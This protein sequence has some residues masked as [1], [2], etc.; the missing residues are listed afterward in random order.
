MF[1][2]KGI[3][4]PL[5]VKTDSALAVH[6]LKDDVI[7]S[8]SSFNMLNNIDAIAKHINIKGFYHVFREENFVAYA[9]AEKGLSLKD[10]MFLTLHLYVL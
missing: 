5:L 3:Y 4:D 9:L 7:Q 6:M 10:F 1:K 8:H 2:D